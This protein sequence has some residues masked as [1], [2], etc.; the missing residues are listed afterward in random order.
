MGGADADRIV[1]D[2]ASMMLAPEAA[3]NLGM[4]LHELATNAAKYGALSVPAGRVQIAWQQREG[5]SQQRWLVFTWQESGG[6]IVQT[7]DQ[8][9]FG[10]VVLE[11]VVPSMFGGTGI[12]AFAD[13]GLTWTLDAPIDSFLKSRAQR[14]REVSAQSSG[15]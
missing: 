13:G 3:Q 10:H 14:V 6:P 11:E 7:P 12:L 15:S 5:S 4:A 9:G 1:I 8:K 2:G